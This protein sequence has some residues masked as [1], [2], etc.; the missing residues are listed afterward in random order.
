MGLLV[1]LLIGVLVLVVLVWA[2]GMVPFDPK[3]KQVVQVVVALLV[4]AWICLALSGAMP[5]IPVV[6]HD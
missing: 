4:L 5:L 6:A 1:T 3:A 2:I